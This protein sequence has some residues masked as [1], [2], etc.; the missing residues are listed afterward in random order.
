MVVKNEAELQHAV[1]TLRSNT[2]IVMA[3]GTYVLTRTLWIRGP[4]VNVGLRGA[5]DNADDVVLIG[6]GM[7]EANYGAVPFG[8]WTGLGVDGVTLANLALRDFY[9]HPVILNAGTQRPHLYNLHLVDAGEQFIKANPDAS[10]AGVHDGIVEYSVIEFTDTARNDY[11][12]G[13]DIH[14]A[15]NWTIRHN[16]F[17]NLV[18]P[19]GQLMGPAVLVWRGTR[20]TVTEGNTF[21]NCARGI[22]Y[23]ADDV[24]SPSHR[25]GIIRNNVFFRSAAQP[26]DVGIILSDSPDTL[27]AHN[28][29]VTSGTYGTPIEYRYTGTRGGLIANNI[30]DGVIQAR[31]GGSATLAGN[32]Q[33]AGSALFVDYAAGDLHLAASAAAVID[34][35]VAVPAVEDDFDGQRRPSGPAPDIGADERGADVVQIR[36]R[37]TDGTTGAGLAGVRVSVSGAAALAVETD[38]DGAYSISESGRRPRIHRDAVARRPDVSAR[39]DR[40]RIAAGRRDGRLHGRA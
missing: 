1:A 29:V 11:P 33:G 25:G 15:H 8:V 5:T 26:G 9:Y 37:V 30:V 27:V 34:R 3:P 38:S 32:V 16:L 18:A 28:T 7:R 13:I 4:L 36:G 12:K 19:A 24:V 23:G 22:M 20:N 35:G 6:P 31:D 21:I 39:A 14:G 40:L 2:T 17:R 10:G